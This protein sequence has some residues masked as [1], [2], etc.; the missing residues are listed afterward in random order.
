MPVRPHDLDGALTVRR[1]HHDSCA[2]CKL[3]RRVAVDQKSLTFS[4]SQAGPGK[5]ADIGASHP[6][7][8][9]HQ[10]AIGNPCVRR[11]ALERVAIFPI[12]DSH[13]A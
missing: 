4:A 13:E 5:K 1:R 12:Q 6:P 3:A 2:P 7:N 10:A 8:T 11:G 9:A